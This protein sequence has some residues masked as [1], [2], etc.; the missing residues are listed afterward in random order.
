MVT[1][2]YLPSEQFEALR[3]GLMRA[4]VIRDAEVGDV[5]RFDEFD[6]EQAELTGR[7]LQ[8]RVVHVQRAERSD[9]CCVSLVVVGVVRRAA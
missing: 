9:A 2:Q 3:L 7:T 8:A 5:L 1:R 4:T 6:E